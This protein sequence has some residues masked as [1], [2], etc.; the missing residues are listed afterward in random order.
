MYSKYATQVQFHNSIRYTPD[1]PHEPTE[2][3]PLPSTHQYYLTGKN[4]R[5]NSIHYNC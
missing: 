4:K 2:T 3:T 1:M 5:N